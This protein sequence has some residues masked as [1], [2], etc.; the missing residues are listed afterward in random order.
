MEAWEFERR[1]HYYFS[2]NS[3][4]LTIIRE[5]VSLTVQPGIQRHMSSNNDQGPLGSQ[6]YPRYTSGPGSPPQHRCGLSAATQVSIY[7][8]YGDASKVYRADHRKTTIS[9]YSSSGSGASAWCQAAQRP[10]CIKQEATVKPLRYR[11][12][13][14]AVNAT[15]QAF[16]NNTMQRYFEDADPAPCRDSRATISV[17]VGFAEAIRSRRILTVDRGNAILLFGVPSNNEPGPVTKL[18][19]PILR[20]GDLPELRKRKM[21]FRVRIIALV[22]LAL[23]PEVDEMLEIQ[24]LA[25]APSKQGRGF[26]TALVN[27]VNDMA[28]A[29]GRKT[30]VI[31]GDAQGFYETVGYRL[32]GEDWLGIDNPLWNGPPVPIRIMLREPRTPHRY[33]DGEKCPS[34]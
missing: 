33:S 17:T 8:H 13:P 4:P 5:H 3:W 7:A 2:S 6:K 24:G 21:E 18:I 16:R 20:K 12:V 23:G 15:H 25:T 30:Y 1:M 9:K 19:S 26:A 28:D 27:T 31:T 22:K 32:V 34:G 29:Q 11:D 10:P 14:R